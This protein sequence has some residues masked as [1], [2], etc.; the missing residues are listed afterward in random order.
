MTYIVDREG[1][2]R[3]VIGGEGI[4]V[5]DHVEAVRSWAARLAAEEKT[6]TP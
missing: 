4:T 2:V 3:A 1:M 5:D 6:R